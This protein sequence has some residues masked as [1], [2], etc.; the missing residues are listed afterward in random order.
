MTD[1]IQVRIQPGATEPA[2]V[3]D[4]ASD[5]QVAAALTP[6]QR[7]IVDTVT[8]D[9]ARWF[10]RHHPVRQRDRPLV[11]GEL[12]PLVEDPTWDRV[13]VFLIGPNQ[14]ARVPYSGPPRPHP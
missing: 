4:V 8:A 6:A 12:A 5:R 10:E 11:R 14:R 13:A 3:T 2:T 9:D 1:T 7:R